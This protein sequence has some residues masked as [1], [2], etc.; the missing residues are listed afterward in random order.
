MR[1]ERHTVTCRWPLVFP[2]LFP[3]CGQVSGVVKAFKNALYCVFFA[4]METN[5]QQR[6]KIKEC[7]IP[8]LLV[9]GA[10]V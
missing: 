10:K 8:M 1:S 5:N 2:L 4:E 3:L 9:E 7:E 6:T